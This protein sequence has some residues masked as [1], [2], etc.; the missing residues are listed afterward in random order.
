MFLSLWS[1]VALDGLQL[2]VC[3]SASPFNCEPAE[4]EKGNCFTSES[5]A[6]RVVASM[7]QILK[8]VS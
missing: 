8:D 7:Q 5:P 1:L 3:L 2:L 6:S 4:E